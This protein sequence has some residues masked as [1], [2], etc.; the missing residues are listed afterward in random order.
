MPGFDGT[1]PFGEGPMTGGG[2]GYCVM[3][4][5]NAPAGGRRY[6]MGQRGRGRGRRYWFLRTGMPGWQRQAA[7]MPAYGGYQQNFSKDEEI[8]YLK[9]ESQL[10]KKELEDVNS[11]LKKLSQEKGK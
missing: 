4:A 10:L 2:F 5:D 3:P 9:E 7:G 1:G 6:V 8:A 11:R